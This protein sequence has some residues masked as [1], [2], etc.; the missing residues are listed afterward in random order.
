MIHNP[1]TVFCGQNRCE[2][3]PPGFDAP[4]SFLF[5]W[6]SQPCE[7]FPSDSEQVLT[8][9]FPAPL[10]GLNILP[11]VCNFNDV[12]TPHPTYPKPTCSVASNMCAT[13]TMSLHHTPPTPNPRVP[14]RL[15]CVQLQ[16]CHY[17]PPHPPQTHAFRSV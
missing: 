12:I 4:L 11:H 1:Y 14:Q 2:I 9:L 8:C 16:R 5:P 15:T 17:T 6:Q 7:S 10:L 3:K 13:S